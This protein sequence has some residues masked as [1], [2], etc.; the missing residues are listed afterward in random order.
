MMSECLFDRPHAP[1]WCPTCSSR[2]SSAEDRLVNKRIADSLEELTYILK[3]TG[4]AA[5]E[6][7]A[8]RKQRYKTRPRQDL[9]ERVQEISYKWKD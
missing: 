3:E 4:P 5:E 8:P 9:Q 7:P 1:V 2:M 6:P